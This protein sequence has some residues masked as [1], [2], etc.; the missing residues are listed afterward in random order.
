M[1][2]DLSL[3]RTELLLYLSYVFVVL[4]LGVGMRGIA[5]AT[6][7][8]EAEHLARLVLVLAIGFSA[9]VLLLGLLVSQD[10]R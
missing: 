10:R 9:V 2:D 6:L 1:S 7:E 5:Y 8:S 4:M 3:S